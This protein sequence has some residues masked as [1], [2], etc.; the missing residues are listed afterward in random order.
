MPRGIKFIL[1]ISEN[2]LIIQDENNIDNT[3]C[4]IREAVSYLK[5]KN[6]KKAIIDEEIAVIAGT[7][8]KNSSQLTIAKNAL[9]DEKAKTSPN[10]SEISRLEKEIADLCLTVGFD[11]ATHTKVAA[12]T[13]DESLKNIRHEKKLRASAAPKRF[14]PAPRKKPTAPTKD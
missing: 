8:L 5:A 3:S 11:K 14:K 10:S 1:S 9:T 6:D 7:S 4:S 2:D 12:P 13:R